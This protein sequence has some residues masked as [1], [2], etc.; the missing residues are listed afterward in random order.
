[1]HTFDGLDRAIIG[2]LRT[3]GRASMSKIAA[4]LSISRATV[5]TR[6]DRL[7]ETGA[8][9]GFT[10]RLRQ[11]EEGSAVRAIMSIAVAGK[12][13]AAVIKSMHGLPEVQ[14]LYTT[15]GAWDLVAE[16]RAENLQDFDRVL[17]LVRE[18]EGVSNSETNILLSSV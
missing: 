9:L 12:S 14:S 2:I 13:T 1:M 5:Q 18:T 7:L 8:V 4:L 15:N 16:I 10:V 11:N 6:L 17:R 3:D